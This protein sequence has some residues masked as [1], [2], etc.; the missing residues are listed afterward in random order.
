MPPLRL[1][2]MMYVCPST[3]SKFLHSFLLIFIF[4]NGEF[5]CCNLANLLQLFKWTAQLR[6]TQI[7]LEGEKPMYKL[8]QVGEYREISVVYY[9]EEMPAGGEAEN[10][11][12]WVDPS[13][14]PEL[15]D[16]VRRMCNQPK[17]AAVKFSKRFQSLATE[18]KINALLPEQHKVG[19]FFGKVFKLKS[20]EGQC[21]ECVE[22][23]GDAE[24]EGKDQDFL[25]VGPLYVPL[26]RGF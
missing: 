12:V 16:R 15:A 8:I 7:K 1:L 21:C 17:Y 5:N 13:L 22:T 4:R 3:T 25:I 6:L 24:E 9:A 18:I 14:P 23:L 20:T 11:E 2:L 10:D 19:W 26:V